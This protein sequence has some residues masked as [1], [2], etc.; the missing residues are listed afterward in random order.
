M[1]SA[2]VKLC[3]TFGKKLSIYAFF[4]S[5]GSGFPPIQAYFSIL[6]DESLKNVRL[7][8]EK[9]MDAYVKEHMWDD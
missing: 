9:E 3:E 6:Q 4:S 1:P 7:R 2:S 5:S 8:Y